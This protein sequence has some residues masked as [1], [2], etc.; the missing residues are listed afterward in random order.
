MTMAMATAEL[1]TGPRQGSCDTGW[2]AGLGRERRGA[3]PWASLGSA[4]SL[5][6]EGRGEEAQVE[7][8]ETSPISTSAAISPSIPSTGKLEP[9]AKQMFSPHGNVSAVWAGLRW[10]LLWASQVLSLPCW[11]SASGQ[12]GGP[13]P[14]GR[15][16]VGWSSRGLGTCLSYLAGWP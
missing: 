12:Q 8:G 16:T 1:R 6:L 13:A 10:L 15:Q 4:P 9:K 2:G 3:G 7:L 5:F 11:S 14:G